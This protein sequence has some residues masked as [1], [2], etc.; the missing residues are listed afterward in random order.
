MKPQS[1]VKMSLF[2]KS[3]RDDPKEVKDFTEMMTLI[4]TQQ[5]NSHLQTQSVVTAEKNSPLLKS[6]DQTLSEMSLSEQGTKKELNTQ[7]SK[8]LLMGYL[9]NNLNSVRHVSE[10]SE[11]IYKNL[12][13]VV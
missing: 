10:M 3:P 11:N 9:T 5:F 4:N 7:F 8:P 2:V 1:K 6:L 12:P 13:F